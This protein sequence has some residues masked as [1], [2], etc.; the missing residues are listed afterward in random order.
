M[1]DNQKQF[2]IDGKKFIVEKFTLSEGFA[3]KAKLTQVLAKMAGGLGK[4]DLSIFK[5]VLAQEINMASISGPISGFFEQVPPDEI[6]PFMQSF[7]TK[8]SILM[9]I[10]KKPVNEVFDICGLK[11]VSAIK[12]FIEVVRFNLDDNFSELNRFFPFAKLV[13][14]FLT[15]RPQSSQEQE[16]P[17]S[18]VAPLVI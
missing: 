13:S 4:I 3:K 14:E 7:L 15:S 18:G 2:E 17:K 16:Q 6:V 9:G 8:T 12:L 5:N 1:I 11:E 10:G